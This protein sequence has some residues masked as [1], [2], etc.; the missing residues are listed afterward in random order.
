M[1]SM[2]WKDGQEIIPKAFLCLL[3]KCDHD[4]AL[5]WNDPIKT[6][7]LNILCALT[8]NLIKHVCFYGIE[9]FQDDLSLLPIKICSFVS[10]HC[11]QSVYG[12]KSLSTSRRHWGGEGWTGAEGTGRKNMAEPQPLG[13]QGQDGTHQGDKG[14]WGNTSVRA[15][16][17]IMWHREPQGVRPL[18]T[19]HPAFYQMR[20]STRKLY[21]LDFPGGPVVKN[22]WF[23]SYQIQGT[24]VWSLAC[25]DYT[26]HRT[27]KPAH[28]RACAL[29]Q[30]KPVQ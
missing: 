10:L 1:V 22:L 4:E 13:T 30:K 19:P 5:E 9:S 14:C 29:Q 26:C 3:S 25:E 2:R 23:D 24:W 16:E 27:T 7:Q 12:N 8:W 17:E 21:Q 20:T 18:L 28:S 11:S 6:A 15:E